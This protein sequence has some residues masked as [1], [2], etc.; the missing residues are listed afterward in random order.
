MARF[1]KFV[2]ECQLAGRGSE[3]K[4]YTIGVEVFDRDRHY[5]PRV[6]PIVRVEARRLRAKLDAWYAGEGKHDSVVIRLPKGSYAP[7]FAGA[8]PMPGRDTGPAESPARG[9]L[10]LPFENVSAQADA[11]YL[12]E[13]LTQQIIHRLTRVE[14]LRVLGWNSAARMRERADV[15]QAARELAAESILSGSVRAGG[16]RL[17]ITAQLA[18]AATG[19]FLWSEFYDRRPEDLLS[20]EEEIARSIVDALQVQLGITTD[21][22]GNPDAY[23]RYFRARHYMNGRTGDGMRRAVALFREALD[24]DPGFALAWAGLADAYI[25]LCEYRHAHVRDSIEPA[26]A[27]AMRALS[28]SPC[29]GEAETSL[30]MI[31]S[32][33]DWEWDDAE[34]HYHRAME[35]SP[36]YA[37]AFQWYG[38]DYCALRGRMEEAAKAVETALELDPLS[39]I[40]RDGRAYLELLTRRYDRAIAEYRSLIQFDPSF[41]KAWTGMGRSHVQAGNYSAAIEALERGLALSGAAPGSALGALGQAHALAGSTDRA[42]EIAGQLQAADATR[43]VPISA[44]VSVHLGLHEYDEAVAWLKRGYER[45]DIAVCAAGVHPLYD[46]LRQRPEFIEIVERVGCL[47]PT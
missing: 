25:L 6:D 40:I 19:R 29:L 8:Q 30:A 41:H 7:L 18:D 26:R 2:V 27:A 5:D 15:R 24:Y 12:C 42:R 20:I 37:T 36:S 10:I 47:E 1:L 16:G 13:G 11:D 44:L 34:G 39:S 17:R 9:I 3:L 22:T 4:E 32:L 28:L 14:T 38:T 21:S 46:P 35:L 45:R 43:S 33:Y 23:E 31:R